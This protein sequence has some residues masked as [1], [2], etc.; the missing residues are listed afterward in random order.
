M[1]NICLI[2]I[3]TE[4]LNGRI[5][6]TNA[7][8]VGKML[9]EA[10]FS[11]AQT[12]VI[13]DSVEAI[14]RTVEESWRCHDVI[15]ISG[16]L[17]PTKD[18]VTKH[19]LAEWW[20]GELVEHQPT[21]EFLYRR[22]EEHGREMNPLTRSQ[23]LVPEGAEVLHNPVGTAPGMSFSKDGK[24]LVSMPGV[25]FEMRTIIEGHVIPRLKD[26]HASEVFL[27][28]V[29][30]LSNVSESEIALEIEDLEEALPEGLSLAFLPRMDGLWLE[31]RGVA[32]KVEADY[33]QDK[34]HQ[35]VT[36]F[37]DRLGTRVYAD[38]DFPLPKLLGEALLKQEASIAV[39][40]S[41]TG[42][43]LAARIVSVSGASRYF[44]GSVTAYSLEA[45]TQHLGVP[46]PLIREKGVVSKEVAM[47]MAEGVQK[48]FGTTYALSTTG[49]AESPDEGTR[50]G[51]WV[52]YAGPDG[53]DA[54][55]VSL[56]YRRSVNIDRVVERAL[57]IALQ[58]VGKCNDF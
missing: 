16:G 22:Y 7:T 24:W 43:K 18:D 35:H 12:I 3:G 52:G 13:P 36:A 14:R 34:L 25:P 4:L 21:V 11:L 37:R 6:N 31:L 51:A 46:E 20:G 17:G 26:Q 39:A 10:G 9:Q 58:K 50:P 32:S 28:S 55:W 23:A 41:L 29:I 42:G 53:T 45:K 56:F 33:L 2:N 40:E 54:K 19:V 30:R 57:A 48:A 1:I 47:A 38:N 15:L 44:E 5:T 49:W 8:E 27:T